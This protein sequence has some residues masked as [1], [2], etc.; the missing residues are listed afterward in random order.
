MMLCVLISVL[1]ALAPRSRTP[2]VVGDRT[3]PKTGAGG[4]PESAASPPD[5]PSTQRVN[6]ERA[7]AAS[8]LA[9]FAARAEIS[10]PAP[11]RSGT[12]IAIGLTLPLAAALQEFSAMT[13]KLVESG[14][15]NQAPPIVTVVAVL[16]T[17]AYSCPAPVPRVMR[18]IAH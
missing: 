18:T 3:S 13:K 16:L 15:V 8:S 5:S 12:S 10:S 11:M 9:A 7:Y 1:K 2:P 14:A 17:I 6:G 4:T